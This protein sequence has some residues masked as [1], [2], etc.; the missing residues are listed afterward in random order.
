MP[1]PS[2]IGS[3]MAHDPSHPIITCLNFDSWEGA[4]QEPSP[5]PRETFSEN[6]ANPKD[7]L[8]N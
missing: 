2:E 4:I 3:K 5:F 7:A 1:V 6:G 8:G